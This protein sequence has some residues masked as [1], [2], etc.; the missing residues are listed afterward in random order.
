VLIDRGGG[1]VGGEGV[2]RAITKFV[3]Y[4]PV[5]CQL[6]SVLISQANSDTQ[7]CNSFV[8]SDGSTVAFVGRNSVG[9]RCRVKLKVGTGLT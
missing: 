4:C 2:R 5:L 6:R 8:Y 1:G 3:R 7:V 9:D